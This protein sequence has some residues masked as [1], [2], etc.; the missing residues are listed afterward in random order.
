MTLQTRTVALA[1][2]ELD[3]DINA[4]RHRTDEG[5]D[6]L[7]ASIQSHG[8]AQSIRVR[9]AER[10]GRFRIV[11]GSRRY[12]VLCELATSGGSVAG[13]T[14]TDEFPVPC[15]IGYEDDD[16]TARELSQAE[17]LIRLPQ[18]EAD[19]Y[20]TFR[21]LADRGLDESQIAA[22]FGIE[23]KRVKRMLALGRLS[24]VLLDA[25]RAGSLDERGS[26][27]NIVRA[28][29]LAP[30]IEE[31][32]RVFNK[33][34]KDRNLHA[35]AVLAAFGGND[36]DAARNIKI[37]GLDAYRAAGGEV[38]QDLFG[39]NHII[40]DKALAKRV[41]DEKIA[42]TIAGLKAEGWSWVGM[43]ADLG[44]YWEQGW[45]REKAG[46]GKATADE[47]KLIKKL[48]K[49]GAKEAAALAALQ[50][51]IAGRQ[52]TP[53]QLGKAGAVVKIGHNGEVDLVRGVLKPQAE[54]K[55]AATKADGSKEKSAPKISDA[56]HQRLSVQ[57]TMA[58]RQAL[59]EEPRLGLVF[60]LAGHLASRSASPI[61]AYHEGMGWRASNAREDFSAAAANLTAMSDT[62]L[63]RV[64]AGI[65]GLSVDLHT[66]EA[67]TQIFGGQRHCL[68][69]A[70][71]P[72]Q[73]TGA[74]L[75][76]FDAPDYF[77]GASKPFVVQAI[78]EALNEDEAR[79]ADKMK[80]AELT[81]F[82]LANV[83]K[84]G[85]LPPELRAPTYSGPGAIPLLAAAP[86]TEPD[87]A[88][89]VDE[90]EDE[91]EDA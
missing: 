24:P 44:Y 37:A 4:R 78:R 80:K 16:Q 68:A 91:M 74:L 77:G 22:R 90:E 18:H 72:V 38:T 42:A 87:D 27:A 84:T 51:T 85:W 20:E 12:R 79:K 75:E 14:V 36:H 81:A 40:A 62:D 65:A 82:A 39:D 19:T 6:E 41:A 13:V 3:D 52:W 88:D 89:L 54:K 48:E 59:R 70:I 60:L 53:D 64:A 55:A 5:V 32:E 35:G 69:A 47:K 66:P 21:E 2:L 57:A 58:T 17:N 10:D 71:D 15:I 1:D 61:K 33:L 7:K 50:A 63:F 25:W 76:A 28:F 43:G 86:P 34:V 29:T 83:P 9:P 26:G 31:Q 11:A 8:L 45:K 23:P 46:D 30:S 56:L 49:A 73:M 67:R